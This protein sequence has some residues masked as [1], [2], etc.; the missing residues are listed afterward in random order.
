MTRDEFFRARLKVTKCPPGEARGS[1]TPPQPV[2]NRRRREA[3]R[4]LSYR[5]ALAAERPQFQ[6]RRKV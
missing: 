5:D 2:T 3:T 1:H 6:Q 4:N